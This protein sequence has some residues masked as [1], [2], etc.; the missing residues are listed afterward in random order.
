MIGVW[1][2]DFFLAQLSLLPGKIGIIL[3]EGASIACVA[4]IVYNV[5]ARLFLFP[6]VL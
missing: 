2:Q 1:R 3:M 6:T 4:Y 5:V